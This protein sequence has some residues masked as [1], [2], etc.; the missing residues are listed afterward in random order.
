MFCTRWS[1]VAE[2]YGTS[3]TMALLAVHA[4][5]YCW[6]WWL[7][8]RWPVVVDEF[9]HRR[10]PAMTNLVE[11]IGPRDTS[12]LDLRDL[13]LA[14]P[15]RLTASVAAHCLRLGLGQVL[16]QDCDL[17]GLPR[18]ALPPEYFRLIDHPADLTD[19][20]LLR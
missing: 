9:I 20:E 3:A 2:E 17:P 8:P 12:G 1:S 11:D 13:L 10:H 6:R 19:V 14:G 7:A 16:P 4:G 15:D 5:R 18:H